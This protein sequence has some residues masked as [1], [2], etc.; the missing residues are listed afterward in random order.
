[1]RLFNG[2]TIR[3]Y[4]GRTYALATGEAAKRFN[5]MLEVNEIGALILSE[6]MKNTSEKE[7]SDAI[8]Q[9]Y[10]ADR[11]VVLS[12]VRNFVGKLRSVNLIID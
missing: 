10:N 3:E 5:G 11:N 7:I 2:F 8:M 12:D 6:L 1:M 4:D 9:K